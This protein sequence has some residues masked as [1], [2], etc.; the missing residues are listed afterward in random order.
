MCRIGDTT[1]DTELHISGIDSD[2]HITVY[3]IISTQ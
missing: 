1:G 3:L 2:V